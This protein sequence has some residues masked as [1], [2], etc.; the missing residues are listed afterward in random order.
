MSKHPSSW[1]VCVSVKVSILH[2]LVLSLRL[3]P[4]ANRIFRS[5]FPAHGVEALEQHHSSHS[6]VHGNPKY[7]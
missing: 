6:G 5:A 7:L 3:L 4:E 2:H 1:P